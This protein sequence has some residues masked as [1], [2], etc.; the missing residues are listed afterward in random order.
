MEI[1]SRN[2]REKIPTARYQNNSVSNSSTSLRHPTRFKCTTCNKRFSSK[3]CLNEHTYKHAN[4]KPISCVVCQMEFRHASQFTL[5]KKKHKISQNFR[6]PSLVGLD[7]NECSGCDRVGIESQR[8]DLPLIKGAK[9][10]LLPP[11][12][13]TL[14]KT[15]INF[16]T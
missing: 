11:F 6:W 5:H 4:V 14:A 7:K 3:H 9:I 16:L 8:L 1:L 12:D 2:T 13:E 15:F 10:Q